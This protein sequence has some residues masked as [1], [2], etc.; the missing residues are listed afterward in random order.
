MKKFKML[1]SVTLLSSAML[2]GACQSQPHYLTFTPPLP[3]ANMQLNQNAIVFVNVRDQRPQPEVSSYVMN[4]QL[5]KLSAQPSVTQL[6][7]Q[8]QQQDLISKG[9]RVAGEQYAN[10]KITVDVNQFYANVEQGDLSY[11]IDT[12]VAL[13]VHVQGAKGYFS[14][15][16][17]ANRNQSGAFNAKNP[18]IQK[19]LEDSL[20]DVV[21]TIYK[22][23]EIVNAISNLAM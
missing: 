23:S 19:V 22:D 8:V 16:I 1:F 14:K 3:Q 10:V 5:I 12:S 2:F 9:F 18:E 21:N 4:G 17:Q 20:N 6:F 11:K 13:T 7:Q 15:N